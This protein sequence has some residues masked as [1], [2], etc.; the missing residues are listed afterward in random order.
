MYDFLDFLFLMTVCLS[1]AMQVPSL[2]D[3]KKRKEDGQVD[4]TPKEQ[5]LAGFIIAAW[6]M[7]E[8]V[9]NS[10]LY[11]VTCFAKI[12]MRRMP[13]HHWLL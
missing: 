3:H 6:I 11:K 9:S 12:Y 13:W 10:I 7:L 8:S 2:V 5:L 1:I 4:H